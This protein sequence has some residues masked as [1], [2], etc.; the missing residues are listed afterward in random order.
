MTPALEVGT[1]KRLFF[2]S[3]TGVSGSGYRHDFSPTALHV[4]RIRGE[5][6]ENADVLA[7]WDRSKRAAPA[8]QHRVAETGEENGMFQKPTSSE[9]MDAATAGSKCRAPILIDCSVVVRSESNLS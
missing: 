6:E 3:V 9:Q 2:S 8:V 5:S 4:P 7:C 1:N